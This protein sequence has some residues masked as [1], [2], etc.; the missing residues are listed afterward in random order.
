MTEFDPKTSWGKIV[1]YNKQ[2]TE[3]Y[4]TVGGL[5]QGQTAII[6]RLKELQQNEPHR[7]KYG[8]LWKWV[9]RD[10]EKEPPDK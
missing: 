8:Y 3:E 1:R 10:G 2:N 9:K 4:E 6:K 7:H 5:I